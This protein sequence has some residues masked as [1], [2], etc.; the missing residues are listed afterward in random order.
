MKPHTARAIRAILDGDEQVRD[1]QRASVLAVLNERGETRIEP[2]LVTQAQAARLLNVSRST[3]FRLA[4]A[5]GLR[6][7]AVRGM[8]RY[9]LS[10]LRRVAGGE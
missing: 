8:R 4:R 6:P 3:M 10:D 7:V 9:R 5:G 1:D 2:F